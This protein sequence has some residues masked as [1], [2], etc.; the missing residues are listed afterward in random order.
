ML[1]SVLPNTEERWH[2]SD[3]GKT[4]VD[5]DDNSKHA[6]CMSDVFMKLGDE[7]FQQMWKQQ[8]FIFLA[9]HC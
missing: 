3:I 7:Q 4:E 1:G 5:Q 8:L 2:H 6:D 9:L